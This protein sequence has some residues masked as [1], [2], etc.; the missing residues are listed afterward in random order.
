MAVKVKPDRRRE[1]VRVA[2]GF[3]RPFFFLL[4]FS[5]IVLG[6]GFGE[7]QDFPLFDGGTRGKVVQ[8]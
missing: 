7:K 3:A 6:I 5:F 1:L 4:R 8:P 2:A